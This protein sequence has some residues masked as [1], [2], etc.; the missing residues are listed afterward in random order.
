MKVIIKFSGKNID[1]DKNAFLKPV[2]DL[3]QKGASLALV[4]GGVSQISNLMEKLGK[5]PNFIQGLRVTDQE[6]MD[7]TEMVL[8]GLLNKTLVGMLT[9]YGITACGIS[10]RDA[11][12]FIAKK[13]SIEHEGQFIDIGWVGDIIQVNPQLVETL[14]GKRILP[15]VSP[16]SSDS[17]GK[18]LNVN[19]DWAAA[20]LAIA[21]RAEKLLL[22]TDVPGVLR[23]PSNPDSL[24]QNL[25]ASEIPLLVQKGIVSGGMIPKL[26]MIQTIL[27]GGVEEIFIAGGASLE[28]LDQLL[29]GKFVPGTRITR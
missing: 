9:Q 7:L 2:V 4:H 16:I 26:K 24:I 3:W 6:A 15:V 5:K 1:P 18:S 14:W 13:H 8:S 28:F 29:G 11:G 25:S 27:Q 19:A 20:Q 22:F 12:L 17:N 23:D 21:L 10:G